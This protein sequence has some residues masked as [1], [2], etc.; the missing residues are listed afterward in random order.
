MG[1]W[2]IF[3]Y[4]SIK[5]TVQIHSVPRLKTVELYLQSHIHLHR[6]VLNEFLTGIYVSFTFIKQ[7]TTSLSGRFIITATSA[8]FSCLYLIWC[9]KYI[10]I[11]YSVLGWD[12]VLQGKVAGLIPDEVIEFFSWSNP[13]SLTMALGST[14]LLTEMSTRNLLGCKR[15]LACKDD[16]LT[17]RLWADCLENMGA[18]MSHNPMGLHGLLQG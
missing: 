14:Q 1:T 9:G 4:E 10:Y 3:R 15:R 5:L 12:T 6:I 17:R 7:N 11:R 8:V 16:N 2:G 13:S 18:S